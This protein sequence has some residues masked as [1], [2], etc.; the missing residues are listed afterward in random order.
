M[1]GL[2]YAFYCE[3]FRGCVYQYRERNDNRVKFVYVTLRIF[4]NFCKRG[5]V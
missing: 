3:M 5:H 4:F 2:S 1:S